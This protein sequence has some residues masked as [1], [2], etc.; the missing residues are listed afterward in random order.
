MNIYSIYSTYSTYP[1]RWRINASNNLLSDNISFNCNTFVSC[2]DVI[3]TIDDAVL[4]LICC[5]VFVLLLLFAL[6]SVECIVDADDVAPRIC[7]IGKSFGNIFDSGVIGV[8]GVCG[9][10]GVCVSNGVRVCVFDDAV[11]FLCGDDFLL[12]LLWLSSIFILTT[13]AIDDVDRTELWLLLLSIYS[14]K[15]IVFKS[16]LVCF[17]IEPVYFLFFF[18]NKNNFTSKH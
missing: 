3:D 10:Y 4:C 16:G 1:T 11:S 5:L 12:W 14:D 7:V 8:F 18:V 2:N 13:V 9:V 15:L 6:Y 17:K